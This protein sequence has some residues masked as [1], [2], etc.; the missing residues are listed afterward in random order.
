M[1]LV[2]IVVGVVIIYQFV[3]VYKTQ[4]ELGKKMEDMY[5]DE[6]NKD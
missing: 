2:L 4:K 5:N 1:D 3:Q 6:N